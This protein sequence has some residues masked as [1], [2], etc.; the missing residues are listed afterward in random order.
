MV[1]D[2]C[3]VDHPGIDLGDPRFNTSSTPWHTLYRKDD[4]PRLRRVKAKRDPRNVFRHRQSVQ[5][6]AT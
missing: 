1:P 2:G 5:P 4:H 3:C 6:P